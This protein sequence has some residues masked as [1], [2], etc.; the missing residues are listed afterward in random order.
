MSPTL[1]GSSHS[2]SLS[3]RTHM[4]STP[5]QHARAAR[6]PFASKHA[7]LVLTTS[8]ALASSASAQTPDEAAAPA[9]PW[10][11]EVAVAS[12]IDWTYVSGA[13]E[14]YWFPEIMG[15][16]VALFDYDGDGD[17]DVYLVQSGSLRDGA[18]EG[19]GN[20][21]YR[22]DSEDG[23]WSFT[24]VTDVAKVGDTG[25]GM[26][27]ACGDFDRDGDVD[28][29]V[30]NVGANVLY[31]NN[32][33]GTFTDVTAK[34]KV[35][36]DRWATSAAFFDADGNGLLDLYVVNNL[37]WSRENE[38]T[39]FNY[40]GERDY[41]SPN[42]Y[43]APATDLFYTYGRLG[44]TDSTIRAGAN[45]AFGN[46]LGVTVGDHDLDG[47]L[48]IYVANDATAN[49][50][51]Q[52]DGKGVFTN[53]AP[54]GG[55]AVNANGTPE[56]GMGVQFVDLDE[57]GDLDLFMTHLRREKN[58][59]YQNNGGR[60][61]DASNM[62]GMAG[63]SLKY[64][65]FG[66]GFHDFD[67]D[68]VRDL[69]VANGAVQAWPT[70]DRFADDPYAEPNHVFRG[71]QQG[72]RMMFELV[73]DSNVAALIGTSRGAAFGDLDNDGAVD[74]VY[75]DRDA[76]VKVLRNVAEKRGNWVGFHVVD[77]KGHVV[78]GATVSISGGGERRMY[79]QADP[80]YSYLAS[81]DPRVQFG[82]GALTEVK[83]IEVRWPYGKTESFP[84][85]AP[86]AYH[87]LKQGTGKQ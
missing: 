57:D 33:N 7:W 61:R 30:T 68:G 40:K 86:G 18:G 72:K 50:L 77:A 31:Q 82:L 36:D 9:R 39:C 12:G 38:T 10:F 76:R 4:H 14:D 5:L 65:G 8:I 2:K 69:Y 63:I 24:D 21:L 23:A 48:D 19:P 58:T 53:V 83:G 6:A 46:G 79:R 1:H 42:N 87:T 35:G 70:E 26:G 43:N 52:N 25:Y 27:A 81:N 59:L 32:G 64:T 20:K 60:Y 28:L 47:D 3:H 16:G 67:H 22:N 49:V 78:H 56:A 75:V 66:M 51:W 54:E 44:F 55:C 15:G 37:G 41:C 13:T 71:R 84:D 17:L 62:T 34:M 80:A 45:V 85:V 73:E 74:I 11:Q 29:F